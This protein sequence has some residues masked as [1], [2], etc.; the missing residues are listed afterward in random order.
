MN[1][2]IVLTFFIFL[3]Y[4]L[5]CFNTLRLDHQLIFLLFFIISSITLRFVIN[6]N[7]NKDYYGYFSFHSYQDQNSFISFLLSEPYLYLIYKFFELFTPDKEYILRGIYWFNFLITNVFFIWLA[8]RKDILI[9]KKIVLFV[10]YYFL[11]GFVLL[12]NGPVY[13]LYA[14]FFYYSFRN[15]KFIKIVLTPFMHLSALALIILLFQR[16]KY[17]IKIFFAAILIIIPLVFIYLIP[18]LSNI[19]SIQVTMSKVYAYS[20]DVKAIAV[21]HKIHFIFVTVI[22]FI[23]ILTIKKKIINPIFITT[24]ISCFRISFLTLFVLRSLII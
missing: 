3:F 8:L 12:R 4:Y 22:V 20:K 9:W 15:K 18:V 17:Y 21:F 13:I 19:S 1:F 10:F 2:I 5:A 23:S 7:S 14:Y 24:F 16:K 11:F 6:P